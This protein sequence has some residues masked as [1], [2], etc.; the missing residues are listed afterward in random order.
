MKRSWMVGSAGLA[1]VVALFVGAA[2]APAPAQSAGGQNLEVLPKT[3]SRSE[4]KSL[5]KQ[6]ADALGVKCQ[7]CHDMGDMS[8]DTPKK[9]VARKMMRMTG[10]INAS[11]LKGSQ[12]KVTCNTC[13]RGKEHP[14][15]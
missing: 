10:E 12:S 6:M 9:E 5:M 14:P 2:S 13:H 8:K 4:I 7:Y 1:V 11:L 15:H 3:L